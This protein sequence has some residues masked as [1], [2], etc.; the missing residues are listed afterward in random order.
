MLGGPPV[1]TDD[2]GASDVHNYRPERGAARR[3]EREPASLN[4][5][6]PHVHLLIASFTAQADLTARTASTK[7]LAEA[8]AQAAEGSG[9]QKRTIERLGI[10]SGIPSQAAA[11]LRRVALRSHL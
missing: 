10:A 6:E 3:W 8:E 9:G 11:S 7:V 1:T 2:F 4:P 5:D